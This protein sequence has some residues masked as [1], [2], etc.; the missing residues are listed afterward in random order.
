MFDGLTGW[1]GR[2]PQREF[3]TAAAPDAL[4]SPVK[5]FIHLEPRVPGIAHL[6]ESLGLCRADLA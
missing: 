3:P 1:Y 2:A 4:I 6:G 5:H